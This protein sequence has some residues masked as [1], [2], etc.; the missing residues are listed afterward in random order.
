MSN[1]GDRDGELV[2][3]M[4]FSLI[5]LLWVTKTLDVAVVLVVA[6]AYFWEKYYVWREYWGVY[7]IVIALI[8]ISI[9]TVLLNWLNGYYD[10]EYPVRDTSRGSARHYR[11]VDL[12]KVKIERPQIKS[13]IQ[14]D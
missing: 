6:N 11:N 8:Y 3:Q 14:I 10:E 4:L 12:S 7:S 9:R 13:Y 2:A 1:K 5:G